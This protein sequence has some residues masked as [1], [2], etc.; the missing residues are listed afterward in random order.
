MSV[1]A[2]ALAL[3]LSSN[4]P[5][6]VEV[7]ALDGAHSAA[8]FEAHLRLPIR[9][10]GH[11]SQMSGELTGEP[12]LGWQVTLRIDGRNLRFE[13]PAWMGT[14]TRSRAFLD[15][16]EFPNIVLHT[17]TI[18]DAVLHRG[19]Q[20]RGELTLR[21]VTRPATFV[22]RAPRCA[23]PGQDCDLEVQGT[24]S[25]RDFGMSGYRFTLRDGV[26]VR[27]HLRWRTEPGR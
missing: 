22:V 15:V 8:E 17:G 21:G 27:V 7:R 3:A 20:V 25:R 9:G 23:R 19:G 18:P 26:D 5:A 14:I 12:A 2:L 16:A 13:G 4:A 6:Q 10:V 11:F 24:V 1:A